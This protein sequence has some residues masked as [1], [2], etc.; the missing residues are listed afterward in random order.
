[1]PYRDE[2]LGITDYS[3][4][5]YSIGGLNYY[6]FWS[7]TM[8]IS[9]SYL[10]II[11]RQLWVW[12][13]RMIGARNY[14]GLATLTIDPIIS[15]LQGCEDKICKSFILTL[16]NEGKN[17]NPAPIYFLLGW[18]YV[19]LHAC[20]LLFITSTMLVYNCH[21]YKLRQIQFSHLSLLFFHLH[22]FLSYLSLC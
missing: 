2:L 7:G 8:Q 22:L 20:W 14:G 19:S 11:P 10:S 18:E 3:I 6:F 21:K 15:F 16:M 1:M 17:I 9:W 4:S 12:W 13:L 5:Y